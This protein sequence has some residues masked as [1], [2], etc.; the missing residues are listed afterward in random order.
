[1]TQEHV[2]LHGALCQGINKMITHLFG[3]CRVLLSF[4]LWWAVIPRHFLLNYLTSA[5]WH[6]TW[7]KIDSYDI[8]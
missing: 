1:M 4:S 6:E 7:Q 5:K 3:R 8:T 2:K